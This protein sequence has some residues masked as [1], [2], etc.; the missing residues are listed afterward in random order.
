MRTALR[1]TCGFATAAVLVASCPPSLRAAADADRKAPSIQVK[2][3]DGGKVR[4][5]DRKGRI[6]LLDFWASWCAPCRTTFPKL[7]TLARELKDQGIDVLA[8]SVD[9]KRKD[10]DAFLAEHP[11]SLE[12]LLDPKAD[13]AAAFGVEAIPSMYVIDREGL[14]RFS[15]PNYGD[16]VLDVV[17]REI[18]T[19]SAA[20]T[21]PRSPS[22]GARD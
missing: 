15:H 22:S 16:D 20:V 19:L 13:G 12:V 1:L 18:G 7:D 2:T 10:L 21:S 6:V 11:S 5:A 8:V 17:K 3:L 4:L 14:I 9:A